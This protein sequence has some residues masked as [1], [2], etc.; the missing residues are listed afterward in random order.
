MMPSIGRVVIHRTQNTA[1]QHN[2]S[3]DHPAIVTHAWGEKS[4]N[5]KVI[6]D[7][8]PLRDETSSVL[9]DPADGSAHGWFW[10]PRV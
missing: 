8:G 9:I 2:G 7:C 4:I 5:C 10:P 6:P 1:F 3:K